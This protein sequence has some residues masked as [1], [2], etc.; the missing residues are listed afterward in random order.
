MKNSNKSMPDTVPVSTSYQVLVVDDDQSFA[1]MI[2]DYLELLQSFEVHLAADI[3]GLWAQLGQGCFD[4]LVLDYELPDGNGLETL[5]E[6]VTQDDCLPVVM[7]T[8][9]GD[10]R[11]AAQAIQYGAA[12]YFIKGKDRFTSL[13][14]L[15][16]KVINDFQVKRSYKRSLGKIRYQALLLNNVRDAVVVWDVDGTVTYWNPAA[17]KLFGWSSEERI[18]KDV[19]DCYLNEFTP[20]ICIAESGGTAGQEVEREV[21]TRE[22]RRIWVSSRVAG[23]RDL[24]KNGNFIGWMDVSRD[25]SPRK[26]VEAEMWESQTRLAQATRMAAIGVLASGVAHQV[27]NPLTTIIADA[28]LLNQT[29]PEGHEARESAQAIEKA[30]WKAQNVVQNLL[31]FSQESGEFEALSVNQTIINALELVEAHIRTNGVDVDVQLDDNLPSIEGSTRQLED[32]WVNLL[33][34][35]RSSGMNWKSERLCIRSWASEEGDCVIEVTGLGDRQPESGVEAILDPEQEGSTAAQQVSADQQ[36][37]M[38]IGI[39]KEIVR[40]HQGQFQY[41]NNA[42]DQTVYVVSLPGGQNGR[43]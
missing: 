25:I 19:A 30:G 12:H 3:K 28:Q 2:K 8:G 18:G 15:I 36:V 16:T 14:M 7:V 22:G 42:V 17:A 40:Q 23:L 4:L 43:S 13:P 5:R 38:E 32:L 1:T 41:I 9:R 11:V 37:G 27:Y 21:R 26:Q 6:L 29:L 35:A 24:E 20:P 33:L 39:C 31:D 34:L 10:E